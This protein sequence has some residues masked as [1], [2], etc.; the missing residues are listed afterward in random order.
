MR[1]LKASA[2]PPPA[3]A[4]SRD[5]RAVADAHTWSVHRW[6]QRQLSPGI[7]SIYEPKTKPIS[8]FAF[9]LRLMPG[10]RPRVSPPGI[11]RRTSPS[12]SVGARAVGSG[13]E[14]LY[15]RPRTCSSGSNLTGTRP[16]PT[17]RATIKALT[18]PHHPP[19]PLQY[20]DMHACLEVYWSCSKI[21]LLS[22]YSPVLQ[23][24]SRTTAPSLCTCRGDAYDDGCTFRTLISFHPPRSLL[25]RS[26]HLRIG[27]RE[28]IF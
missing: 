15:G 17:P 6:P 2:A 7:L 28:D 26:R 21:T 20:I 12:T 16:L 27:A 8:C 24:N 10:G 11:N 4:T 23:A 14:G 5:A 22:A 3:T 9:R 25:L 18:T 1:S 13:R 19:S